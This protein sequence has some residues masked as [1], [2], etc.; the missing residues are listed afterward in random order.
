MKIS[1]IALVF[2]LAMIDPGN[3]KSQSIKSP[4]QIEADSLQR[5][6][7]SDSL[8]IDDSIITKL[9]YIRDNYL[10]QVIQIRLDSTLSDLQTDNAI[11]LIRTQTNDRIKELLGEEIYE[12]YTQMIL[13]RMRKKSIVGSPLASDSGG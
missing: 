5:I 6:L 7:I 1:Y 11:S 13:M 10:Q 12:K 8:Q 4:E 2:V 3:A 9:F